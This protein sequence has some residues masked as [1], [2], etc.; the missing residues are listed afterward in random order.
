MRTPLWSAAALLLAAVQVTRSGKGWSGGVRTFF[1]QGT[2]RFDAAGK[3][4][5]VWKFYTGPFPE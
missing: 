4:T 1:F 2:V 3:C 5:D